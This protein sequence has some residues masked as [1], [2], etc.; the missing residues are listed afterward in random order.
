M[1]S[2]TFTAL[3]A[4]MLMTGLFVTHSPRAQAQAGAALTGSV[5]S[6]EEGKMEGVVVSARR[7]G[8]TFTVSVVTNDKGAFTFPRTH[9]EPGAYTLKIRAAGYDLASGGTAEV[10]AGTTSRRNAST[11]SS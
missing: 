9:L 7:D 5:T 2:T 10:P 4:A 6:K 8:T 11:T 1:R 3:T